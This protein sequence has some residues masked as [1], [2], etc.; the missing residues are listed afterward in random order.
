M[1][2]SMKMFA[3]ALA[4]AMV[5]GIAYPANAASAYPLVQEATFDDASEYYLSIH[6]EPYFGG[7]YIE[8]EVL[9]VN[10]ASDQSRIH[11]S[12]PK[13]KSDNID[14]EYRIV[15]Y[16]LSFLE[17][18]MEYL[19][20]QMDQYSIT[21]LDANDVT[22]KLDIALEDFSNE[23]RQ[24][25]MLLVQENFGKSDFLNFLDYS[26]Y[27]IESTVAYDLS[28]DDS[29][30]ITSNNVASPYATSLYRYGSGTKIKIGNGYF[31][32]GP[33]LSATEAITAGHGFSFSTTANVYSDTIPSH[34]L[35]TARSFATQFEMDYST[36][37]ASHLTEFYPVITPATAVVGETVYMIGAFT[38]NSSGKVTRTNATVN[39]DGYTFIGQSEGTYK[40]A[41]GDSGAAIYKSLSQS[42]SPVCYGSQSNARFTSNGTWAGFSY[43]QAFRV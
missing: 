33:V 26:D 20:P 27:S 30:I 15:E 19:T 36:I 31:T 25:I 35:G 43:F 37:T 23:N 29:E 14:V 28:N 38:R 17:D 21:L 42:N 9:V 12:F 13:I 18:I 22:N 34:M 7:L 1:K 4:F 40:C 3:I 2:H 39:V 16:P 41:L 11:S 10:I 8:D 32:L 5:A 6:E 24:N